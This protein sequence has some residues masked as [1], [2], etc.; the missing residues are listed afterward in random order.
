MTT[1]L[2]LPTRLRTWSF[3]AAAAMLLLAVGGCTARSG[4][5]GPYFPA[6]AVS[7]PPG[8]LPPPGSCRI[9]FPDRPPGHQPP[10]G[11]CAQLYWQVPPGAVL[12]HG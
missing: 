3:M 11:S 1:H 8:H 2:E 12:V 5:H 6:A 4:I 7:V 9:W 10:P